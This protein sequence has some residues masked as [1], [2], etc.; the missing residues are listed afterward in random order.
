MSVYREGEQNKIVM[1][2]ITVSKHTSTTAA[3]F[4][5]KSLFQMRSGQSPDS[6]FLMIKC[7]VTVLLLKP[8]LSDLF[9]NRK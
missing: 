5:Q 6:V 4:A 1:K 3:N 7:P 9:L 2:N 8:D